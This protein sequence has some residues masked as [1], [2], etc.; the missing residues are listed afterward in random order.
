MEVER[1]VLRTG[2]AAVQRRLLHRTDHGEPVPMRHRHAAR[3]LL[4]GLQTPQPE[5]PCCSRVR[6]PRVIDWKSDR[7]F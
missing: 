3:L 2:G 4:G 5:R 1:P 6:R 7:Y